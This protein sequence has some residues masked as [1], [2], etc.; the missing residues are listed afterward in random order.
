MYIC[1]YKFLLFVIF[2]ANIWSL[3]PLSIFE[4]IR[5]YFYVLINAFLQPHPIHRHRRIV[6]EVVHC[7][8]SAFP[9]V[10]NG[11]SNWDINMKS[12]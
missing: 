9:S 4:A 5:V 6:E 11:N 2:E 7:I 8:S 1:T 10:L 12:D 3:R